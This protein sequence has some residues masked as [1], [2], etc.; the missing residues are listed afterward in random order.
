MPALKKFFPEDIKLGTRI[1]TRNVDIQIGNKRFPGDISFVDKEFADIFQVKVI[2]G[3]L[4]N[5]LKNPG[6]IALSEFSSTKYFGD[7]DPVGETVTLIPERGGEKELYKVTAVYRFI[8]PNTVLNVQSFSLLDET[9]IIPMWNF[10]DHVT[11]VRFSET[12]NIKKIVDRFPDFVDK[13]MSVPSLMN[14]LQPGQ[15]LSEVRTYS[16]QKL[17]DIYFTPLNFPENLPQKIGNKAVITVFI[18]ISVIILIIGCINFIILNTAKATQRAREIAMRKVVGARFKQ[19]LIQFLFES[20]LLTLIAFLF[21]VAM[22]ELALPFF[23]SLVNRELSVPYSSTGSYIFIISILIIVGLLSGLY[24]ALILSRFSPSSAL[25]ANQTTKTGDSL[26]LRNVLIIFQ[27]TASIVLIISTIVAYFQL[28][29]TNKHDP[30]FNPNKLL[31]VEAIGNKRIKTLQHEMLKLPS[32]TNV[33][34]STIQPRLVAGGSLYIVDLRKKAEHLNTPQDNNFN[35]MFVDYNFFK[36]YDIPLLSGRYF[37]QGMDPEE[38]AG[39]FTSP[40]IMDGRIIINLAAARQLGYAS[41][42]EAIEEILE[43]GEPGTPGYFEMKIVG[44]VK[45]S[46]YRDLRKKPEPEVYRLVPDTTHFLTVKYRGE[47]KTVLKE[48][49]SVWRKVVGEIPFRVS[50]VKQN[51]AVTFA[52]E[53]RENKALIAFTLLAIFIAC[54]GLFGMAA[55]TVER[56]VK[57]IGLR[58]VMGA[59]VKDIVSLLGWN[60]LKPVLIANIIAWPVAIFA[61]QYWLERFPYRFDP[62]FMIPICLGS[63]FIALVIAWFT[64]ASNTTRVAKSKPIKALRYE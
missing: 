26:K 31:V 34:L 53:E 63:G 45:N 35:C 32:V 48:I 46:Q 23:E 36:T 1:K 19:L 5:T 56:R 38:P 28:M 43:S 44:V 39:T 18:V 15:K 33:A 21:A 16:L 62:L 17:S 57:E 50:N 12:A 42:N 51:L 14:W 25:K 13:N 24:P 3:S 2:K 22:T 58:K 64:V 49:E 29:Y 41:A 9:K 37:T 47:Y 59:K 27:F 40:K 54:M 60:F 20:M 30:G 55:F 52:Q 6:N 61:M 10:I 8:S 4:A 11:Y 7:K